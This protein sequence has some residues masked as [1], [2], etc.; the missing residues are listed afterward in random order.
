MTVRR[1]MGVLLLAVLAAGCAKKPTWEAAQALE[2][3]KKYAMAVKAYEA[4]LKRYP[5]TPMAVE[6]KIHMA[7]CEENLGAYDQAIT[8]YR[9]IVDSNPGAE[10][11]IKSYLGMGFLYRDR[12]HQEPQALEAFEKALTRYLTQDEVRSAIKSLVEAKLQTAAAMF[13]R[14]EFQDAAQVARTVLQTYPEPFVPAD[15][16]ARALFLVDRIE[17][18]DRLSKA[19][20]DQV[21]VVNETDYNESFQTD[22][23]PAAPREETLLSPDGTRRAMVK[24][25]KGIP[26]LYIGTEKAGKTD[27]KLVPSSAGV[28]NPVWSPNGKELAFYRKIGKIQKLDRADAGTRKVKNLY[29]AQNGTLGRKPKYDPAGGKIAFV[30]AQTVWVINAD[31]TNKTKLK[32]TQPVDPMADLSWSADGTLV[33]YLQSAKDGASVDRLITLDAIRGRN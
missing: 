9:E 16:R 12:L 7:Q 5:Q 13:N 18:G 24:K 32:T 20:S 6:A 22:F 30:Y 3:E 23:S 28:E 8:R 21:F 19:D 31:G 29:Y 14:K 10:A 25:V 1:W 15:A 2:T 4:Y 11:E 17:R 33:R 27:Y 26:F